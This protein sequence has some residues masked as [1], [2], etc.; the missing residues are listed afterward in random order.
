MVNPEIGSHRVRRSSSHILL[1]AAFF[2]ATMVACEQDEVYSRFYH[3]QNGKWHSDSVL[4]FGID[5]LNTTL[6]SQYQVTVELTTNRSYPY[7]DLSLLVDQVRMDTVVHT[8]T[9]NIQ[10]ADEYG[11]WLGSGIGGLHQLSLPYQSFDTRDSVYRNTTLTLR[12]GMREN[13]LKGIEKVGVKIV[14]SD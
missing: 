7:S 6:S 1:I 14:V 4:V 5:S 12:H 13:Q 8:D 11:K 10:L 2:M 9:F 3:L